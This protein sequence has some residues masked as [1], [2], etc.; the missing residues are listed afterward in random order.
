MLVSISEKAEDL[1]LKLKDI[2]EKNERLK[3]EI[4]RAAE[5]HKAELQFKTDVSHLYKKEEDY[6]VKLANKTKKIK[7]LRIQMK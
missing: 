6:R 7:A 2:H 5:L 3:A 4:E 1:T